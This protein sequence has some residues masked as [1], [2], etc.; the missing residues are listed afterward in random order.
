MNDDVGLQICEPFGM[1]LRHR[2]DAAVATIVRRY[3]LRIRLI[4][5]DVILCQVRVASS[6]VLIVRMET[7]FPPELLLEQR[8]YVKS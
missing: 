3:G 8:K 5:S 1:C 7:H 2:S 4:L 6:L